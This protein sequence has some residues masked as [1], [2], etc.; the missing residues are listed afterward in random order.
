[1]PNLLKLQDVCVDI[2]KCTHCEISVLGSAG[3]IIASSLENV[4]GQ[5]HKITAEIVA[6]EIDSFDITADMASDINGLPEGC[7]FGIDVEG[8]RMA[9]VGVTGPLEKSQG[10][11]Q[12]V[13]TSIQS[14]FKSFH[15][16]QH[17]N[18][19]LK[20]VSLVSIIEFEKNGII[21]TFNSGAER[22]L[23]YRADEVVGKQTAE[24][25]YLSS[26]TLTHKQ[27]LE[28]EY[29]CE[30]TDLEAL[31]FK[32][33]QE[34]YEEKEWTLV[35][36]D[37]EHIRVNL[38]VTAIFDEHNELTGFIGV[39]KNITRRN[40][41]AIALKDSED[42]FRNMLDATSD[43]Y[44]ETDEKHRFSWVSEKYFEI[45]GADPKDVIGKTRMERLPDSVI[46]ADVGK[47][48]QHQQ[49]LDN[50][51]TFRALEY[52][53][54]FDDGNTCHWSVSGIPRLDDA[55]QFIG[56]SGT[57]TD[58]SVRKQAE[59]ELELHRDHLQMLVEER[60]AK[61][62]QSEERFRAIAETL[63][64]WLWEMDEDLRFSYF[65]EG[66]DQN[67][68]VPL[69]NIIGKTREDLIDKTI[70][71]DVFKDHLDDINKYREFSNFTY[72]YKHPNGETMF[73]QVSGKPIFNQK[74]KFT[75]YRGTGSN[76]TKEVVAE[77]AL[78]DSQ[79][80]FKD[81][82]ETASDWFWESDKNH[83][84]TFISDR[85]F[86]VTKIAR[87]DVIGKS[88]LELISAERWE[89][90]PDK[91]FRHKED[92]ENQRPFEIEYWLENEFGKRTCI[93][94]KGK[95]IY[96]EVGE[97][98][99]FRG[100]GTDITDAVVLQENLKQ[101]KELAE[102][103]NKAKSEFL[104]SMSHEL[105]TPLNAI[106]GFAQILENNRREPLSSNQKRSVGQILKGGDHLLSLINGILDLA[107]IESGKL[108]L[109][110]ETVDPRALI[111]DCLAFSNTLASKR[112]IRLID[113]SVP[114]LPTI[115]ADHLRAKQVI[116]NLL[117]NAIKY[118]N[119]GGNV[120]LNVEEINDQT[121]RISVRDNG[122]GIS[123]ENQKDL[124]Q[125]FQR[126]G[127]EGSEIEG[128]GIGLVLTK[129]LVEEMHGSIGFDSLVGQGST[130]WV[131][132]PIAID[133]LPKGVIGTGVK[134]AFS[135]DLKGKERRILYIEDNPSNLAMMTK[136]VEG[137]D[138]LILLAAHDAESG[139]KLA[140]NSHPDVIILDINLPGMNG[141]EAV[142]RLKQSDETKDI[143]VIAL[144]ADAMPSTIDK[145]L[146]AGF[147]QYLTKP[148]NI[149][150]L[151]L[152]LKD[153][154]G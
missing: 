122:L 39:A 135:L 68:G 38:G 3:I 139:L 28:E 10:Y 103:A 74:G 151:V 6:G 19:V 27:E 32:A 98:D 137:I 8:Q 25:I 101:A 36:R 48:Q 30:L 56:Y 138:G 62:S 15:T 12:I 125:P 117:S 109:S 13:Q 55:G 87:G 22:M 131:D 119:E 71:E 57:A 21:K 72:P 130:F 141:I 148:L 154:F 81:I 152:A 4:I 77:K 97:F 23:G 80:R 146:K 144:S 106:L 123:E 31:T 121:V 128:T 149:K 104:S 37:G 17:L 58:I 99:G 9:C 94:I 114:L 67:I 26:E 40:K 65:T 50:H 11:A 7:Y 76:V 136:V 43:W 100:A 143:Q 73:I 47:W 126:L 93:E 105:R 35:C 111:D 113:S 118:N 102:A 59:A 112:D 45:S 51:K 142:K 29:S 46:N 92:L 41:Y 49:D 140:K 86:D 90:N 107:K 63:S 116:L 16:E 85:F 108:S 54:E 147:R 60:T 134:A 82:A 20:A 75:G 1:M 61:L 91:W 83:V 145:G 33:Q 18:N 24:L 96:N 78:E 88:R 44:W 110:L 64:D 150:K 34:G 95:P 153:V 84:F 132:L 127:A 2:S 124:F 133:G 53:H 69:K 70:P 79:R 66:F 5:T 115:F 14:L 129:K 89:R 52:S 120:W 42:R